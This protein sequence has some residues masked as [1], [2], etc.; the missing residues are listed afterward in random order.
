MHDSDWL[1]FPLNIVTLYC[2]MYIVTLYCIVLVNIVTLY[3]I[4]PSIV[5]CEHTCS[6]CFLFLSIDA[7]AGKILWL[8]NFTDLYMDLVTNKFSEVVSGLYIKCM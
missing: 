6:S 7:H 8:S 1:T 2:S 3:C 4:V 5:A